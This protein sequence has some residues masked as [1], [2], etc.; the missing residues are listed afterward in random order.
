MTMVGRWRKVSRSECSAPYPEVLELADG[1][2]YT[3]TNEAPSAFHPIWDQGGWEPTGP[4]RVRVSL[5]N[6]SSREYEFEL[7]EASLTFVDE[8][9]CRIE[10]ARESLLRDTE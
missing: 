6:D 3:G 4:G 5:A 7:A 9:G 2:R 1:G 8:G 10:Y